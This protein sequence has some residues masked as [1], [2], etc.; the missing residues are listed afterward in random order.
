MHE[1][2]CGET[3]H[4]VRV[5]L[6]YRRCWAVPITLCMTQEGVEGGEGGKSVFNPKLSQYRN[7]QAK[8]RISAF[9]EIDKLDTL[10]HRDKVN[11]CSLA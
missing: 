8:L 10:S 6:P 5:H 3:W 4:Q 1:V 2:L 9:I 7:L 11:I